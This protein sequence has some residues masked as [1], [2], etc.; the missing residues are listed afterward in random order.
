MNRNGRKSARVFLV[1]TLHVYR[2]TV[3]Y[4]LSKTDL[5]HGNG[6]ASAKISEVDSFREYT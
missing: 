2:Q 3:R 1:H 6:L 5:I 4:V